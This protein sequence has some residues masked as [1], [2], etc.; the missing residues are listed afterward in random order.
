L[1]A[2]APQPRQ[3]DGEAALAELAR[4]YFVSHGPA[5]V[6]DFAWWAGLPMGEARAGLDGAKA[7]LLSETFAGKDYWLGGDAHPLS[8]ETPAGFAL[9]GFDEYLLGYTDRSAVLDPAHASQVCPGGNGVFFPMIVHDGQIVGTW[10]RTLKKGTV[11]IT[12][13]PFTAL[14]DAQAEAFEM[15]AR[16][17]ADFLELPVSFG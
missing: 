2:W 3:L 13:T 6:H 17:Y 9:P 4:R 16:R 15:A 10:K 8:T 5:T 7:D 14:S 12:R 11:V 1:E